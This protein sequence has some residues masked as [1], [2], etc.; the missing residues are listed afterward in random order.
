MRRGADRIV[1]DAHLDGCVA[2]RYQ[3]MMPP[4]VM[5]DEMAA[6]GTELV[7]EC[8]DISGKSREPTV[9]DVGRPGRRSVPRCSRAAVL[10]PASRSR[11]ITGFHVCLDPGNPW[12][13]MA[14]VPSGGPSRSARNVR[15]LCSND[16]RLPV[17]VAG[18]ENHGDERVW[19]EDTTTGAVTMVGFR[20]Y[21][22]S[23]GD[24]VDELAERVGGS[25]RGSA[26]RRR[27]RIVERRSGRPDRPGARVVDVAARGVARTPA[28]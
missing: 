8:D 17:S 16:S 26:S 13:K 6:V 1:S 12:R 10:I 18:L 21:V 14:G 2:A 24:D 19:V 27:G 22:T 20:G 28:R 11:P 25:P 23:S 5:P 7:G 15:P 4:P 3:A 9:V